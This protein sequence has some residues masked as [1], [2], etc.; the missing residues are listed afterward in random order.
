MRLLSLIVLCNIF[1]LSSLISQVAYYLNR[2]NDFVVTGKGDN[3]YWNRTDWIKLISENSTHETKIKILY[4]ETGIY[5]LFSCEDTIL[6]STMDAD[7][8]DLWEEDVVE[9]FLWPDEKYPVYFEY[10]ISPRNY[11]LPILV[12][13]NNG[14]L[15]R[16]RPFHY[17]LNR[18]TRHQ[19]FI[20][21]DNNNSDTIKGWTAEFFIP[22]ILLKPLNNIP[23]KEGDRWRANFYRIDYDHPGRS[24]W[25]WQP[26]NKSFHEYENFGEIVFK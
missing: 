19:T 3:K 6:T 25:T 21:R 26:I 7:F 15:L 9:V 1:F 16:W 4:S 8:S 22:Y 13:N 18:Q 2:S 14:E 17:E 23:P 24:L 11:E 5:F 12:F 10:E 20:T